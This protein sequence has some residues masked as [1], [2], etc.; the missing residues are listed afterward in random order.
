M[1]KELP[2]PRWRI[3]LDTGGTFTDAIAIAPDGRWHRAKVPS[4]GSVPTTLAR[5][6]NADVSITPPPWLPQPES[7][8]AGWSARDGQGRSVVFGAALGARRYRVMSG[9]GFSGPGTASGDMDG[10][11]LA[12]HAVTGT[13]RGQP[14]PDADLRLSTTRGTNALLERRGARTALV[15]TE[16]FADLLRIGDQSRPDLFARSIR[17]VPPVT[18]D[19][20]ALP[21][22]RLADGSVRRRPSPAALA[23]LIDRLRT[24]GIES[25]AVAFLHALADPGHEELVAVA[26]R[27]AGFPEVALASALAASPRYLSRAETATAHAMLAPVLRRYLAHVQ[28]AAPRATIS[29]LSSAG[30]LQR[31]DR[32]L[33]RDCLLSGPA[34][35]LAGVIEAG[36]RCGRGKLLGLDMGGTSADVARF[37]GAIRYRYETRI[38]G[39]RV[40]APALPIESV[41]AG[42]GSICAVRDGELLVGPQSAGVNPGPAAF[43][44]GG[45]LTLTD[46]QLLLGR[47]DPNRSTVPL[48]RAAAEAACERLRRQLAQERGVEVER[49]ALLL[50]LIELADERMAGAIAAVSVREGADPRA[51]TLVPF[52]GAGG[53]HACGLAERLGIAE[54]LFPVDAGILSARGLLGVAAERIAAATVLA[55]L[56]GHDPL[57]PAVA[58]RIAAL[59]AEALATLDADCAGAETPTIAARIA[60]LRLVGTEQSIDVP[61]ASVARMREDFA[62][63]FVATFGHLPP[64]RPIEIEALRSVARAA[65]PVLPSDPS[66]DPSQVALTE[67]ADGRVDRRSCRPGTIIEGPSILAETGSTAFLAEGWRAEVLTSGDVVARAIG[68]RGPRPRAGLAAVDL[69]A[70]RLEA[71]AVAMGEALRRTALSPNVKER[72]DFSCAVLDADGTLVVNAPHL[73]VHLG[74]IGA[75]VRAV[76]AALP[77]GPGDVAVTNHPAFGGSH[78]PDVTVIT[79]VH[80]GGRRIGYVANRAHHA[81][82]GG[83]RPGS[84]PPSARNLAEEGVVIAPMRL[85]EAGVAQTERFAALLRDAPHPSRAVADNL[86]DLAAQMAAN[87]AGARELAS[88]AAELG[89]D[90]L[91]AEIAELLER[92]ERAMRRALGRLPPGERH[93]RECLDDGTPIEVRVTIARGGPVGGPVGVM[94]ERAIVDFAGSGAVHPRGFNAPLAVVR[95]AVLYVLRL[96]LDEPVPLHEGLLRAIDLRVPEGFLHPPFDVDPALCPPVAAG[97][98]ETS[99]R[100]TDALLRA[101]GLAAC[102][103][104]TMN[105]LLF[106]NETFAAYETI[107]GGSGATA[108]A[109]GADAVHTHMTNTRI[110]DAEVLERRCPVVIREFSIRR[111]SGGRGHRRGG[112]GVVR[113][114]EFREPVQLSLL[115]QHRVERPYGIGGGEPGTAG[116]QTV[117]RSGGGPPE[118]L[119]GVAEAD[120]LPGDAIRVETPGGGGWGPAR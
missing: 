41:A 77:L 39:A 60:S 19:V 93:A 20:W 116:A 84:F 108:E 64:D 91:A 10:P 62:E 111:G 5:S 107:A 44:R 117:L 45:P 63:S 99:Q 95:S 78:L 28:A 8:F 74:A 113:E 98:T 21:E 66:T 94:A 11:L 82:I 57:P 65:P 58:D 53:L 96:L 97:N 6:G 55:P 14:L 115:S 109:D 33:A 27:E 81:E 1:T 15:V 73:P 106:G 34:G 47:I 38:G 119:E 85:V 50:A 61:V 49:A 75:C 54:I 22:R 17:K 112:D 103:Q 32:F 46:V 59:D 4:D 26:L 86:A 9:T 40:A 48:D 13:P 7:W 29:V 104:G 16:G 118:R 68:P 120:L 71:I 18:E 72:L 2:P 80:L 76:T 36:R 88:L 24:A 102:S 23:E 105:N 89:A 69:L 79:P 87:T 83:T 70:A 110:T 51:Y 56:P 90:R 43:G 100:V 37:D 101:L 52:G 25:V 12:V 42:G 31:S 3:A 30:G 35:G 92:G 114:I 67:R